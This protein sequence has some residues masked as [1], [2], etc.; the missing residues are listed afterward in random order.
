[1]T[2]ADHHHPD[3]RA[4]KITDDH[5]NCSWRIA[6]DLR[7]EQRYLLT[8][9]DA[10]LALLDRLDEA[11]TADEVADRKDRRI[12]QL[13]EDLNGAYAALR[14]RETADAAEN[15]ERKTKPHLHDWIDITAIEDLPRSRYLCNHCHAM[16][17][18]DV[19]GNEIDDAS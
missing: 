18:A 9:T 4:P 17:L 15:E 13:E 2:K 8:P 6:P 19:K 3:C 14:A 16:K 11:E 1:M 7:W 12:A 5:C 10:V